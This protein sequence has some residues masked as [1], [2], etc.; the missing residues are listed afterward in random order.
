MKDKDPSFDGHSN[1]GDADGGQ[2]A[3]FSPIRGLVVE[4]EK[5]DD[6]GGFSTPQMDKVGNTDNQ[7]CSQFLENP[8]VLATAIKMTDD[9]VLESYKK[10]KKKGKKIMETVEVCEEDDDHGKRGKRDQK[11]P[12]YG[13]STFVERV[14]RM[15]D[16]VKKD[17][18]SLYNSVFTSKRDYGEEI[19]NI[20]SG[21]MLHQGFAYHFKSNMFIHAIIIDYWSSLLNGMEKLRDVGSI[22]RVFFDTNFLAEEI[23]DGSLSSGRSQKLFDSMLK[24]HLK[25]LP[26]QEKLK[27]IGLVN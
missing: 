16:K 5:K 21:H 26:K 10:E 2:E 20:A 15:S 9:A 19:W 24:L 7:I 12:V 4:G 14:V 18:M 3:E 27:D 25:S 1:K 11:I 23:L 13:K 8:E 6:G 17:E 22:S